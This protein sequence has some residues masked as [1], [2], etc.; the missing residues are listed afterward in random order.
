MSAAKYYLTKTDF[1]KVEIMTARQIIN[2]YGTVSVE[3]IKK[4][5]IY[6]G[7]YTHKQKPPYLS[8]VRK[9]VMR[10]KYN[11]NVVIVCPALIQITIFLCR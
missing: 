9:T 5:S 2:T 11:K 10:Y 4:H 6:L 1:N 3:E 7:A 8:H